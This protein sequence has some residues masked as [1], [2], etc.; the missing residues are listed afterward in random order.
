M[1]GIEGMMLCF[2]SG[3]KEIQS[4]FLDIIKFIVIILEKEKNDICLK[5]L[6]HMSSI[7]QKIDNKYQKIVKMGKIEELLKENCDQDSKFV[8]SKLKEIEIDNFD[9]LWTPS[10]HVF[11]PTS[12]DRVSLSFLLSLRSFLD[13][14][15][16]V[17]HKNLI[18]LLLQY[19]FTFSFF[20]SHHSS[21]RSNQDESLQ[22]EKNKKLKFTN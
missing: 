19:L 8:I 5:I 2:E 3:E 6:N 22:N 12:F 20:S 14:H 18:L 17:F 11:A 13:D 21:K 16:I 1:R 15:K 7:V 4:Y 9:L 10:L